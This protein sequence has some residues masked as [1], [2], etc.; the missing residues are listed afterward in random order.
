MP[1][2][3]VAYCGYSAYNSILNYRI[4][5]VKLLKF[6]NSA[7]LKFVKT[8]MRMRNVRLFVYIYILSI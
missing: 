2:K 7:I 3:A 4:S 1:Y 5:N 8:E 6:C